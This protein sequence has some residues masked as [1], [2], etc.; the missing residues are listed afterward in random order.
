MKFDY[1]FE[2]C[3]LQKT[4]LG[5]TLRK[6]EYQWGKKPDP[7]IRIQIVEVDKNYTYL[8]LQNAKMKHSVPVS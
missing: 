2:Q 3:R 8:L 5:E 1:I 7:E 4:S 6:Y